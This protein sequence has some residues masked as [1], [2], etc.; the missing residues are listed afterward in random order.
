MTLRETLQPPHGLPVGG[1]N[2][3]QSSQRLEQIAKLRARGIG[4][5]VGLPQL[6]VC[7]DQSAGK[8]SV[9]EG[10]T[11]IPFPRQDGLCT[12]FPTEIILQHSASDMMIVASIIP[13]SRRAEEEK[14]VF[15]SFHR[16]LK[17]FGDMPQIISE[18]TRMFGVRTGDEASSGAAFAE[19]VLRIEVTGPLG[20]HLSIV[21]LPG[22]ISVPNEEQSDEDVQIVHR[23]V[24]SYLSNE[25][26]IILAV[27]QAG[28]DIANQSIIK[29][30]R[31]YDPSGTR[32][33]GIIT[34][35]DLVNEGTERR[36]ALLARNRDTTKLKLG[37]FLVRNP[38]PNELAK[39][40]T[41]EQR[42]KTETQYF[43][44][45]PYAEL[46]LD[47][48]RT[49][50]LAL[51][52]FLQRL[53]DQHVEKE[54]PKVREDVRNL[55]RQ[56]EAALSN[57]GEQRASPALMRIYLTRLST[58]FQRLVQSALDGT[59]ETE[60]EFFEAGKHSH[61]R[62]RAVL[63]NLNLE[64]AD[65]MRA[66]G[67]KRTVT[68]HLPGHTDGLS[69]DGSDASDDGHVDGQIHVTRN[70]MIAWIKEV[71]NPALCQSTGLIC[72]TR[73]TKIVGEKSCQGITT[74]FFCPS[75]SASTLRCGTALLK[76]TSSVFASQLQISFRRPFKKSLAITTSSM[77]WSK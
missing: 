51:Q 23:L 17:A 32:T 52:K 20:L 60:Y 75:S 40:V 4:D 59:Y 2:S 31:K 3:Q 29:K 48:D 49:G 53:L 5:H 11:G 57:M 68:E 44:D 62:L 6:V 37:F 73:C 39:G 77:S 46:G 28:N 55:L 41:P 27:V 66:A 47:P 8:S 30:S 69:T 74:M 38:T 61:R 12:K 10:L 71:N 1:L 26:T 34:K 15:R 22:L 33:V 25:R 67:H 9:L 13:S 65:V 76:G 64:F 35:P 58:L 18:V 50:I 24:D 56:T 19:D 16:Q 70:E 14:A 72:A 42:R 45:S 54:L 36:I 63:H 7:G 21:D 43:H